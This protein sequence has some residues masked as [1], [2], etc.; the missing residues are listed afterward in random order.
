MAE[1][2]RE[3]DDLEPD[4]MSNIPPLDRKAMTDERRRLFERV[5]QINRAW[6]ESMR[7]MRRAEAE[8]SIRL[9]TCRGKGDAMVLC[10]QWMAK[11][12]EILAAEQHLFATCWT[13]LV[14]AFGNTPL[15]TPENLEKARSE[16]RSSA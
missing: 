14:A 13:D 11:R 2:A 6:L 9:F 10:N 4:E 16:R 15:S 7:Q 5:E 1:R 3:L 8:F 12:L